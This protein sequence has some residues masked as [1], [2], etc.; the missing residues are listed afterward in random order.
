M[1]FLSLRN[2]FFQY[3]LSKIVGFRPNISVNIVSVASGTKMVAGS[4][5]SMLVALL[6]GYPKSPHV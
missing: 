3:S 6:H 1:L 2:L 4:I 5:C